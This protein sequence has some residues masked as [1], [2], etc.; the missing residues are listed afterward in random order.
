MEFC[1]GRIVAASAE[2]GEE[3]LLDLLSRD[4][5]ARRLGEVGIGTNRCLTVGTGF[6]LLDEKIA[7][8]CHIGI[9]ASYPETGGINISS[10]HRDLVIDLRNGGILLMEGRPVEWSEY[11]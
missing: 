4:A 3:H 2:S 9:G 11:E 1:D 5:G 7:G 8:T 6:S 10:V